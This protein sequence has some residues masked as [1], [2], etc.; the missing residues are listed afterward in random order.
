MGQV[1]SGF[2]ERLQSLLITRVSA[3]IQPVEIERRLDQNHEELDQGKADGSALPIGG[4]VGRPA[5]PVLVPTGWLRPNVCSAADHACA[6]PVPKRNCR[7][8]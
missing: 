8:P 3:D 7:R 1:P 5:S 2:D 6:A 4:F